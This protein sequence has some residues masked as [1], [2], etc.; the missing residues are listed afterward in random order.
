MRPLIA[1]NWK[2]HGLIAQ[3]AEIEQIAA[4]VVAIKPPADILICPPATLMARAADLALQRIAIGG[5]DCHPETA[6]AFTGDVSAEMLKDAGASAVILGHSERRQGHGETNA[7]VA[8]KADAARRAGLVSIV[9]I[10]ETQSQRAAGRTLLICRDQIA[11]SL[12]IGITAAEVVIAHEPLWAIGTGY[13]PTTAE[14]AEVH[15]HIRET[16]VTRFGAEGK[17]VRILYGGSVTATNALQIL[18]LPDVDGALIG[19]ASLRATDFDAI[20]RTVATNAS[21]DQPDNSNWGGRYESLTSIA[22][23][24]K[25]AMRVGLAADH[26]GFALKQALTEQLQTAGYVI[27]DFGAFQ[28][29][30]GD[31]YPDFVIPLAQAVAEGTVDR[32]LALCGSGVGASVAANKVAGVRAALIHD[33]FSAHQGVEDD[34]M[35]I[36]CL[37]GKV[38]GASLAIELVKGFLAARFS[39]LPRHRRR[40]SKVVALENPHAEA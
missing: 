27:V 38:I 26:G 12:P 23:K 2:M 24:G 16:L 1:G 36:L 30:S 10:G 31:D 37:G 19:G 39:G 25:I 34:D 18:A 11:G 20:I 22:E 9:C 8:A 3:L 15:G 32:G 29:D 40:L 35:N 17:S 4:T 28:L 7:M 13:T 5:Q 6:G 21:R 33:I 14:I